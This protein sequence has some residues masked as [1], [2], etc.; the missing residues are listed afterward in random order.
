MAAPRAG[1]VPL[2]CLSRLSDRKLPAFDNTPPVLRSLH[3]KPDY[4]TVAEANRRFYARIADLYDR[5]ES[6]VADPAAQDE[7]ES[8]L[9]RI[10][11]HLGRPPAELKALDAC[12]GSGN[13]ALKL[14]ARGLD[15]TVADISSDLLAIFH[16]KA[17]TAGYQP[18]SHC[19]EIAEFLRQNPG[20]F[21]LI[22]FSSA[23]HHLQDIDHVL[24]NAFNS[25]RPGGALFTLHDPTAR[26]QQGRL[27]PWLL[28]LEY[29]AFKILC[30]P[31][32]VPAAGWRRIKRTFRREDRPQLAEENLGVLAE[33]HARDGIDDLALVDRLKAVGFQ[34]VEHQRLHGARFALVRRVLTRVGQPTGF[35]L[36]LQRP[37]SSSPSPS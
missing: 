8:D 18:R 24:G 9:D 21:D 37:G 10:I 33:F 4:S 23:L 14:L 26:S 17:A 6:C 27:T 32:D 5:T 28:R 29:V 7:L 15:V 11:R 25:L 34:V 30:Q 36:V 3:L 1:K 16:R 13:V 19:G 31:G 20:S 12:G 2:G 35:K 22:V